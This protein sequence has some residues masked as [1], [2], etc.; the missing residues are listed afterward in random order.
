MGSC[1]DTDIDPQ[2][3]SS[4]TR[5]HFIGSE[6]SVI[7]KLLYTSMLSKFVMTRTAYK[8]YKNYKAAKYSLLDIQ[9][10]YTEC[11][12]DRIMILTRRLEDLVLRISKG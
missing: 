1:P 5:G 4:W 3:S 11:E 8:V 2:F 9:C 12:R 6:L 7:R 10:K